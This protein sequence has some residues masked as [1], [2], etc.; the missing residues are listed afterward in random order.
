MKARVL[1]ECGWS[2]E[3]MVRLLNWLRDENVGLLP[4]AKLP[5]L[6]DSHVVYVT[7]TIEKLSDATYV[8]A[9]GQDDCD[10]LAAWRAAELLVYGAQA[11]AP[12]DDGYELAQRLGLR[13][14]DAQ[15]V[16]QKQDQLLY[17]AVVRYRVGPDSFIDDPSAKLGMLGAVAPQIAARRRRLT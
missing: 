3:R 6:Y 2:P 1:V 11:L 13:S 8:H 5:L 12:G 14:I 4:T 9:A 10:S 7:E 15:V 17:H 16:L